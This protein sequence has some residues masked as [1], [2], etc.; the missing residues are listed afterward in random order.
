[1]T[2]EEKAIYAMH[3]FDMGDSVFIGETDTIGEI[4]GLQIADGAEDSYR[5]LYEDGSGTP[6]EQWWR[7]SLLELVDE[8]D[9]NVIC[10]ACAKQ[11][12][13]STKH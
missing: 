5:V 3:L 9:D 4:T 11:A 1:M 2:P 6:H 10:F 12:R 7:G 13:E 8:S